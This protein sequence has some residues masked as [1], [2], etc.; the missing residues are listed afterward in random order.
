MVGEP[1]PVPAIL[2]DLNFREGVMPDSLRPTLAMALEYLF[3]NMICFDN[4]SL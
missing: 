1:A 4:E 2:L 3:I